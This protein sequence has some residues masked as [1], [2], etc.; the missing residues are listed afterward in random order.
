MMFE[1]GNA[2]ALISSAR[3]PSGGG[4]DVPASRD[5]GA[6]GGSRRRERNLR[7]RGVAQFGLPGGK[8][9]DLE[10][11]GREVGRLL[12][13]KAPGQVERHRLL[14]LVDEIR[15]RTRAPVREETLADQRRSNGP[16]HRL[17]VTFRALGLVNLLAARCLPGGV[18][19]F[20]DRSQLPGV[21]GER[22]TLRRARRRR[23]PR[24]ARSATAAGH[25]GISARH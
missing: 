1:L 3:F 24:P 8:L 17:A 20:G 15:Q 9:T 19:T 23:M 16:F 6:R 18:H 2:M 5:G 13:G 12:P 25:N 7:Q 22:E 4:R 11:V 10:N 14:N 21:P